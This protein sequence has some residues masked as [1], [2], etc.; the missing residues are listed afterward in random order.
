MG[1]RIPP[2]SADPFDDF[3]LDTSGIDFHN[4]KTNPA[5]TEN[6]LS[7]FQRFVVQNFFD[8]Q[9]E[10]RRAFLKQ[11]GFEMSKDGDSYRPI[12]YDGKYEPIDPGFFDSPSGFIATH[13][14]FTEKGRE[15]LKRDFTDVTFDVGTGAGISA[16]ASKGGTA[17]A[18]AGTA[19]GAAAGPKGAIVGRVIGSVAGMITSGVAANAAAEAMKAEVGDFFLDEDVPMDLKETAYQSLTTGVLGAVA[20]GGGKA[21]GKIIDNWKLARAAKAQNALKEMA[22]R[23]SN[24]T[25]SAELAKDLAENPQNYTPTAV[26]GANKRLLQLSDDIFGT[27]VDNP[28]TTRQLTG[29]VAKKAIDPLNRRADLEI[30]KLAQNAEANFAVDEIELA[31]SSRLASIRGKKFRTLEEEKALD[32]IDGELKRLKDKMRPK[33]KDVTLF[34]ASGKPIEQAEE[35]AELNFKEGRDFLKSLQNAAYAEGPLKDNGVLRTAT[36]GLKELAD[37]KATDVGSDLADINAKRSEILS[38]YANFRDTVK[39]GHIQNAYVG[40]DNV[41]RERAMRMFEEMDRVLDTDLANQAK[42]GQFQSTV[43]S[44]YKNPGSAFGSGNATTEAVKGG[45]KGGAKGAFQFGAAG[46]VLGPE[47]AMTA[48]KV[49]FVK[50]AVQGA[51][52]G[53]AFSSPENLIKKFSKIQSRI[54]DIENGVSPLPA[55]GRTAGTTAATLGL[56]TAIPP[57]VAPQA[58]P[59]PVEQAPLPPPGSEGARPQMLPEEEEDPFADFQL[60]TEGVPGL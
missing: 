21:L 50:G 25:F 40:K 59:P 3:V 36:S 34:D 8:T 5:A 20:A 48:A 47:A 30:E 49:G 57:A 45:L 15:E 39:Q 10:R 4:A 14:I 60:D 2:A 1:A 41:S 43:E 12:G 54:D 52:E 53:A 35:L 23:K 32:F 9:P 22:I 7:D 19:A 44:L 18:T 58:E 13:N 56:D 42:T 31:L 28:H 33:K 51:K 16:A 46:S 17:G 11:N 38:T 55:V 24:G 26:E 29:G 6:G 37:K 27:S